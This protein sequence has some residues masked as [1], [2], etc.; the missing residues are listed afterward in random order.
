M[1]LLSRL[2]F[3]S[4][5]ARLLVQRA[6]AGALPVPSVSGTLPCRQLPSARLLALGAVAPRREWRQYAASQ[7]QQAESRAA[8]GLEAAAVAAPAEGALADLRLTCPCTS[9]V[10]GQHQQRRTG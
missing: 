7:L 2:R 1:V 9:Q 5:M 3:S 6:R 8:A 4:S 10:W